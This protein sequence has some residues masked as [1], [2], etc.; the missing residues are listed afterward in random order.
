LIYKVKVIDVNIV[1][2]KGKAKRLGRSLGKTSG[3]K[4]AIVTLKEGDKIDVMPT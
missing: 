3:L 4:K 1:N 2:I